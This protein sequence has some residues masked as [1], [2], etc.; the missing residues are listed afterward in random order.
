MQMSKGWDM[1]QL[2]VKGK[3]GWGSTGKKPYSLI[4]AD[5]V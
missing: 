1:L 4:A 2:G 5:Y 3:G